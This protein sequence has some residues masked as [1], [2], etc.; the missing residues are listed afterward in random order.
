MEYYRNT[1]NANKMTEVA[2]IFCVKEKSDEPVC[3]FALCLPC[4]FSSPFLLV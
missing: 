4:N 3:C 1:C 2:L